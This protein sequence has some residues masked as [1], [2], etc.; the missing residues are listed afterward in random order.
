M[1]Q[2]LPIVVFFLCISYLSFSQGVGIGTAA[3]DSSAQLDI[4]NSGKG[5]LIPRMNISSILLISKPAKGLMAYDSVNNQLMVNTGTPTAPKWQSIVANSGW[6]LA[7]NTGTKAL[8]QF[9]GTNEC[10]FA[11]QD[12]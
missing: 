9:I 12:Q 3:P 11:F 8:N 5:L 2:V 6:S 4:S 7:G 10:S 1:K